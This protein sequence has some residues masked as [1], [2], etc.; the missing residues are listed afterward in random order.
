MQ[1]RLHAQAPLRARSLRL[2]AHTAQRRKAG[3]AV[4]GIP[5]PYRA[6]T[7]AAPTAVAAESSPRTIFVRRLQQGF[8][9]GA[10]FGW[11]CLAPFIDTESGGSELC[12]AP[13]TC[14]SRSPGLATG[15][16]RGSGNLSVG[17]SQMLPSCRARHGFGSLPF[18]GCLTADAD[19]PA[20][21]PFSRLTAAG[22]LEGN[23]YMAPS[24]LRPASRGSPLASSQRPAESSES[25]CIKAEPLAA[26]SSAACARRIPFFRAEAIFVAPF[27]AALPA[28]P[29]SFRVV[30]KLC[31]LPLAC[32]RRGSPSVSPASGCGGCCVDAPGASAPTAS[33]LCGMETRPPRRPQ[34]AASGAL[35]ARRTTTESP[36]GAV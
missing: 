5:P 32:S 12:R 29:A 9:R 19:A 15:S 28:L 27:V 2:C 14:A 33:Y 17:M 18:G 10:L 23:S 1:V 3:H 21:A 20:D 31:L 34:L 11:A 22:L 25:P 36:I 4:R 35:S 7:M 13:M 6:A 30:L 16:G 26:S 8:R 24:S